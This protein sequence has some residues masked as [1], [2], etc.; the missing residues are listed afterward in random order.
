MRTH[1]AGMGRGSE[2]RSRG[3][4]NDDYVRYSRPLQYPR[5][6]LLPPVLR[7]RRRAV[8]SRLRWPNLGKVS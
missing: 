7:N 4:E 5:Q 6:R 3:G 8:P 2:K 1:P